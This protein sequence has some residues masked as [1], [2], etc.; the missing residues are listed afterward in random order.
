MLTL[1]H[2]SKTYADGTRALDRVSLTLPTG[3]TGLLGT[4]GAGKSTLLRTLAGIQAP[5]SGEL[6]LMGQDVL[7]APD[8]LRRRLGYLPQSFGVYPHMSCRALLLYLASLKGMNKGEALDQIEQLLAL[9]HLT[10]FANKAVSSFSGG[11]RQRFGI[12]QA[13]LGQPELLILDEPTAG[14]DPTERE[15]LNRVLIGLS[16]ARLVLLSTHIVEDIENLCQRVAL[17]HRGR[18][19]DFG[20]VAELVAPMAGKVWLCPDTTGLAPNTRVLSHHFHH[21]RVSLRL[22]CDSQPHPQARSQ[23]AN[24]QDR[25]FFETRP[26]MGS[27]NAAGQMEVADGR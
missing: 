12:A 18:V 13:L 15:H 22:C 25:Y 17:M 9:T 27:A 1:K 2:I 21:G 5:D 14:L 26:D 20:T 3:M 24:L 4:N 16:E 6:K 19:V 8:V 10:A 11:M 7:K 23:Q